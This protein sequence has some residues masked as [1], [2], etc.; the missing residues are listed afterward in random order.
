[1][2]K[3]GTNSAASRTYLVVDDHEGFR[4]A[5]RSY[6]PGNTLTLVECASGREAIEAYERHLPDWTLMDIE[7][8]GMDGFAAT[9][10]ILRR[11]ADARVIILTQH[12]TPDYREEARSAG[13]CAFVRKDD[14]SQLGS[15]LDYATS[16]KRV[17][18]QHL[19]P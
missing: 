12:D 11:F 1:M 17:D 13:A 7:M 5:L 4:R 6:L 9:R 14:L 18:S 2:T 16:Q 15:I 10:E 8:P 3:C 19:N